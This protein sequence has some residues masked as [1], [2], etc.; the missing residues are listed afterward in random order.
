MAAETQWEGGIDMK[1]INT[2]E[3]MDKGIV[4]NLF[5]SY[6][7]LVHVDGEEKLVTSP[8]VNEETY[9]DVASM[10]KV[11]VTSTLILKAIS[12]GELILDNKLSDFFE[13]VPKEKENITIKQLLTHSSGIVRKVPPAEVLA[14]NNDNIANYILSVPLKF[15]PGNDYVYS[16]TGYILLGFILEKLY[17]CTLDELFY[18]K[19]KKPL[20]LTRSRFNIPIDEPNSVICYNRKEVGLR[21]M[22]DEIVINMRGGVAGSGGEFW[23]LC[24]IK[25]FVENVLDKSETLYRKELFVLAETDYTPKY[26]EGRGLGYLIVDER[27]EQTGKLFPKGSFGHCG[28]CGQSIFINREKNMYV[29]ILSNATRYLNMKNNFQGYNYKQVMNMRENIHNEIYN[30]LIEEGLLK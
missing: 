26:E 15:A 7:V 11:L 5:G 6:A 24:D 17:K 30:D 9:F 10:G 16:C 8:D 29:T 4:D 27:Y 1:L 12:E 28:H 19:L 22:D 20:G 21:R 23:G 13:N 3:F 14:Q 18:I 25:K 2:K